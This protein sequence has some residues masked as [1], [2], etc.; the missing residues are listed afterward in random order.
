MYES[1]LN[2]I[3]HQGLTI[4]WKE[5]GLHYSKNDVIKPDPLLLDWKPEYEDLPE[6][7]VIVDVNGNEMIPQS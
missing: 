3:E 4:N 1:G 5:P 2:M 7:P 6:H